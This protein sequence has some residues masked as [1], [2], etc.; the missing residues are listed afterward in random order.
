MTASPFTRDE[1]EA[2]KRQSTFD[3]EGIFLAFHDGDPVGFCVVFINRDIVKN[4][5]DRRAYVSDLACDRQYRRKGIGSYLLSRAA[6]YAR[7]RDMEALELDVDAE[8]PHALHVYE[9]MGF[10][11]K[12]MSVTYRRKV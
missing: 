9:R 8:N 2:W 3:P 10:F 6:E 7:A 12:K 1:V 4:T 11:K 5:G